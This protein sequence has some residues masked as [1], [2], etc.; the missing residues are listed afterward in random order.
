MRR[1]FSDDYLVSPGKTELTMR[2]AARENAA[3]AGVTAD[4]CGL[5]V[6]IPF[7]PTRCAYCSFVSYSNKKLFA[8]IPDYLEKLLA[9]IRDTAELIASLGLRLSAI[10]IGGG[11]PSIL[12]NAQ[13]ERLFAVLGALCRTVRCVRIYL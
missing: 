6:S 9:D 2:T 13:T 3:L 1:L 4:C 8:L 5:Y 7:C 10:Y 12:D 11:T